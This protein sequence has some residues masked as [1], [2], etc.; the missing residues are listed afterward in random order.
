MTTVET[1]KSL[2]QK[3]YDSLA[4]YRGAAEKAENAHLKTILRNR[5]SERTGVLNSL[6]KALED[7]GEKPI[8]D[9]S[10][11]AYAK[12]FMQAV[13]TAFKDG[14]EVAAKQVEKIEDDLAES[15]NDAMKRD[16]LDMGVRMLIETAYRDIREGER[17]TDA[18][19]KQ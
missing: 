5:A 12:D 14:D 13:M 17:I 16:D 6:N 9:A 3:T 10:T 7:N 4:A 19:E 15:F 1:L 8:N 2:S 18:L 11:S